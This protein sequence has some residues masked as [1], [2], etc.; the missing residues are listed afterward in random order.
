MPV[1]HL[2]IVGGPLTK[3]TAQDPFA[4]EDLQRPSAVAQ[5]AYQNGIQRTAVVINPTQACLDG[6]P[7]GVYFYGSAP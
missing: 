7:N 5:K 2:D 1:G 3:K 6:I 4:L